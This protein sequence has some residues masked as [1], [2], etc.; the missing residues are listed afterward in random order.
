[1][2]TFSSVGRSPEGLA[3]ESFCYPIA[4]PQETSA[5]R[6]GAGETCNCEQQ[7][8]QARVEGLRE[9]ESRARK[10]FEQELTRLRES[11]TS[12]LKVFAGEREAYYRR[13]EGEV[14][15]LALAIARKVL[16]R[17]AQVDPL[18]L[19]GVVDVA[20][21]KLE[22]GTI[23]RLHVGCEGAD[24]WREHLAKHPEIRPAPEVV[25]DPAVVP[26]ACI[27]ET[28]LGSTELGIERQMK[29]IENGLLDLLAQRPGAKP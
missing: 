3:I 7:E 16:H 17:E 23:V 19:A 6:D 5:G 22:T 12:A 27:L 15:Q 2:S 18:L 26:G 25:L 4:D 14:V 13:V 11:V 8:L 28:A 1:M 20:L 24:V 10:N 29:E 9:G 21:R